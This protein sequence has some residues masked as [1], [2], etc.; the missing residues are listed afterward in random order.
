MNITNSIKTEL[1]L[2]HP[3]DTFTNPVEA[4]QFFTKAESLALAQQDDQRTAIARIGLTKV[5]MENGAYKE[6]FAKNA[7]AL[8]YFAKL[9]DV[10]HEAQGWKNMA[11]I[12]GNLGD[13]ANQ[14]IFNQKCLHFTKILNQPVETIKI[15]NNIGHAH[16]ELGELEKAKSIFSTNLKS[17]HLTPDLKVVS[18]KNLTKVYLKEKNYVLAK[19]FHQQ[20]MTWAK[21]YYLFKYLTACDY[22]Y[23]SIC[24]GEGA[25]Q[26]ALKYLK[27]AVDTIDEKGILRKELL[28][29]MEEYISVL[30]EAQ[31][32]ENLNIYFKKYTTLN[33]EINRELRNQ[34]TKQLQFQF[35]INEI[36]KERTLLASQ[37]EALQVANKKIADQ[38]LAL[39]SKS[40]QLQSV[41]RELSEF[42]HRIAHDLK[43]PIRTINSFTYLLEKEVGNQL[44][45]DS[46]TYMQFITT[47]AK[48]L[49]KFIDEILSYAQSDQSDQA[50]ESVDMMAV[51]TTISNRLAK[52]ISDNQVKLTFVNL[53]IIQ[54]HS[55][56]ILQVFQNII[57]NAIKFKR[58]GVTPIINVRCVEADNQY[59]FEIEDNGIG[60][61][62]KDQ[63]KIFQLFQRLH[64]KEEFEGAGI[65]L[66]TVQKILRRYQAT[67]DLSSVYGEGTVFRVVF[68]K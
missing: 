33:E 23:G 24:F 45:A 21:K 14:L 16:F 37:N 6:A 35:E 8:Q 48:D 68:P 18:L 5:L 41:N 2:D 52:Q 17:T 47:S 40:T 32:T 28:E 15:L 60:I 10:S 54:A 12:Y 4:Y 64:G 34:T 29:M 57:S 67:I 63:K 3:K 66:S 50:I 26:P 36:A 1:R 58:V 20:T 44:S 53:P 46:L 9:G 30:I 25:I 31:E 61:R 56:L 7:Q 13:R 55:A 38:K 27:K 11:L 51:L 22:L 42:A 49:A 43:Q 59:L 65:G 39:E 62:E 19:R